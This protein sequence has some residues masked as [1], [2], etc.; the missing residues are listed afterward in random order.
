[1]FLLPFISPFI[2]PRLS[3]HEVKQLKAVYANM[4]NDDKSQNKLKMNAEK[5][6]ILMLLN[7]QLKPF[8]RVDDIDPDLAQPQAVQELSQ[9]KE[10]TI[11]ENSQRNLVFYNPQDKPLTFELYVKEQNQ[12]GIYGTQIQEKQY[13]QQTANKI[14]QSQIQ[15]SNRAITQSHFAA[16]QRNQ[17]TGFSSQEKHTGLIRSKYIDERQQKDYDQMQNLQNNTNHKQRTLTLDNNNQQEKVRIFRVGK[18]IL[19][20][21]RDFIPLIMISQL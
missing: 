19:Y 4:M 15:K 10:N 20:D 5:L 21:T 16:K 8:L 17:S 7:P 3:K 14:Q 13:Q 18:Q 2:Q 9:S 12:R 1:M 11:S 6:G